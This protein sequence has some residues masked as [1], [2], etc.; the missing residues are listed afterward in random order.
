MSLEDHNLATM[1]EDVKTEK[2]AI[3]DSNYIDYC[4]HEQGLGMK[5]A[6]DLRE[7]ELQRL[8]RVYNTRTEPILRREIGT[9][10]IDDDEAVPAYPEVPDT[11]QP[12]TDEQQRKIDE[13]TE[14]FHHYS[15][16]LQYTLTKVTK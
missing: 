12:F 1:L 11:F 16:A 10:G 9:D 5:D 8:L 7:R 6:E 15:R 3:T 14:A 13:F 2:V 4:L